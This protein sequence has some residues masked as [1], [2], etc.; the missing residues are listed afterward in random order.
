MSPFPADSHTTPTEDP[1]GPIDR[2]PRALTVVFGL[3]A[4]TAFGSWFYGF[5][6]LVA[7]MEVDGLPE[8]VVATVY[9]I[10]LFGAGL[11]AMVLGR[12]AD[13]TGVANLFP[14]GAAIVALGT[15]VIVSAPNVAVFAVAAVV[16]GTVIGG[17]G[18]YSLL[19]A[20]I[21]RVAPGD[22]TRA[23]TV[24]TLWGALASPVFLPLM[25]WMSSR[26]SWQTA[27]LVANA[28]VVVSLVVVGLVLRG[29]E[30]STSVV[31]PSSDASGDTRSGW[32]PGSKGDRG[33]AVPQLALMAAMGGAS[34]GVLILY[35]VPAMT[36]AGIALAMASTLAGAR[37]L[38]QLLGRLPLPAVINRVGSGRTLTGSLLLLAVATLLLPMSGVLAVAVA[39][40]VIGGVAVGAMTT[41]ENIFVTDVVPPATI[42]ASLGVV[43][44]ARGI[45]GAV[46]P[47]VAG[48]VTAI[49][50]SRT[51]V[52]IAVAAIALATAALATHIRR[53]HT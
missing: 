49:M 13:R 33:R 53:R 50:G 10:S 47:S 24:N 11:M 41:V 40:V 42:G 14:V 28:T 35:Q 12:R 27:M 45:G 21:A 25:G 37:G 38:A 16:T 8:Q 6:V 19:H 15:L 17:L 2:L 51:P 22:R 29:R 23:I 36:E 4:L 48:Q 34:T 20:I 32:W 18:Y 30:P 5:G 7:L 1:Q 31:A 52:L 46:G 43:A 39:F 44:L 9:G 3:V 26:W